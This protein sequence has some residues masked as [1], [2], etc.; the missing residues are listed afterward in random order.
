MI[1]L[2][3]AAAAGYAVLSHKEGAALP[4]GSTSSAVSKTGSKSTS[5]T[6]P[7][8][9]GGEGFLS[10]ADEA[11][12]CK[13]AE[14]QY[15]IAQQLGAPSIP[16]WK[17]MTCRQKIAAAAPGG[18]LGSFAAYVMTDTNVKKAADQVSSAF[19]DSGSAVTTGAK[20]V[21]KKL[22]F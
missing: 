7:K 18:P 17:N 3:L 6:A 16:N 4:A 14:E 1:V 20:S 8:A 22:G 15:A 10:A 19:K 13:L 5:A 2:L 11:K 12:L 9:K 21:A